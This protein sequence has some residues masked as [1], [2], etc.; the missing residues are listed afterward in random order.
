[1]SVSAASTEVEVGESN[2][3]EEQGIEGGDLEPAPSIR[4]TIREKAPS[5]VDFREDF[6]P[7]DNLEKL[8][9]QLSKVPTTTSTTQ[10]DQ[11]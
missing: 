4:D 10:V 7:S 3:L 11:V 2:G 6:I 1:M 5:A 8:K 9:A